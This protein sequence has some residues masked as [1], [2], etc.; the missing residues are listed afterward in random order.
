MRVSPS[1]QGMWE[2]RLSWGHMSSHAAVGWLCEKP[3][4]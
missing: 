2:T 3:P 4:C 1:I